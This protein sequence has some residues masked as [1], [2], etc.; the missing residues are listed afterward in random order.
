LAEEVRERE[1]FAKLLE[2]IHGVG[3]QEEDGASGGGGG[4]E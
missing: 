2:E 4:G 1:A 3:V